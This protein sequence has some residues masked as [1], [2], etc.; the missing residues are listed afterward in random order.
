VLEVRPVAEYR[1]PV[2]EVVVTPT[3]SVAGGFAFFFD[4]VFFGVLFF[5]VLR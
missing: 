3:A 2:E 1:Q 5:S 4:L